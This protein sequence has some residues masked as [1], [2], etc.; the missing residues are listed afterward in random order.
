MLSAIESMFAQLLKSPAP[1]S[2]S[3][4]LFICPFAGDGSDATE[5]VMVTVR[6]MRMELIKRDMVTLT[7]RRYI[8]ILDWVMKSIFFRGMNYITDLCN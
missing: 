6:R 3:I 7:G 2:A 1:I 8:K 5:V 4:M